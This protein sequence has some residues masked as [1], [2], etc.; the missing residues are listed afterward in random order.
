ML[1]HVVNDRHRKRLAMVFT[2]D[3]PS[4][5]G[6]VCCTM[7]IWLMRLSTESSSVGGC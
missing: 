6:A 2:T 1:F 4:M 3:N 7:M 5:R